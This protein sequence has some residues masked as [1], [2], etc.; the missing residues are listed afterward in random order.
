MVKGGDQTGRAA[1]Y[2]FHKALNIM[3]QVRAVYREHSGDL[4]PNDVARSIGYIEG[5]LFISLRQRNVL[6][7]AA[8]SFEQVMAPMSLVSALCQP[9][10]RLTWVADEGMERTGPLQSQLRWLV[11]MLKTGTDIVNAQAKLGKTNEL[12]ALIRGMREWTARLQEAAEAYDR[13]P[14]LPSNIQSDAHRA[15]DQA[16]ETHM[17]DIHASYKEWIENDIA[18]TTLRHIEP[19]LFHYPTTKSIGFSEESRITVEDHAKEIFGSLDL[20]LGSMQD[21]E[22][23]VKGIPTSTDDASWM[24]KEEQ[25]VGAALSA[26]HAPQ[27]SNALQTLLDK[28]QY[29]FENAKLQAIAA[30][31]AS[32]K[33]IL[34]Q[35]VASHKYLLDRFD[36]LHASTA[37]LLHRLSKSFIQIGTQGFCQPPEKSSDQ[38]QGKD[39]KL[40]SGTGLGEGEGAEDISKD[41]E[42]DEDLE[43]LAQEQKGER[44]G[45]I[46]E[47]E[48]AVDMG[49]QEMQGESE[50]VGEKEDKGDE[51][52]DEGDDDVQSEV[53][54]VDDL[55]PSAVDEKMWDDGGKEDD[56]KDKEGKE[57]VGTENQE[58]QVAS[59]QKEK[60]KKEDG[61]DGEEEEKEEKKEGQE[62][63]EMEMEGEDQEEN[64]GVGET[65]KMDPH[66]KEEETLDL[67]EDLNMDGQDDEGKEDDDLG[68]MD[69]G[70][71]LPED[72]MDPDVDP[73][74]PD[75][76]DE[77]IG[78]EKEGEEEK[79][80]TGHVEDEEQPPEDQEEEGD[81][82]M[83]DDAIPLPDEN[84]PEDEP[85][86]TKD[87]D[88]ADPNADAGAGN[89]ANEE[90][91]KNK[92]EEA[93]AS[94]ANQDEGQ[95]GDSS[96]QKQE[97]TAEDGQ[98]GQTAAPDAGG[99]GE[100]PEESKETQSFKKLGDVL[101]KWYN[102]QKQISEAREKEET[103]VQ[104]ID[105]EVDMADADFEHLGDE[106]QQADTQ[107][108]GTATE[109]Q[110]KTLDHDMAMPM[111]EEEEKMPVRPEDNEEE[112]TGADKDVEMEDAE[113][114][115]EQDPEAQQ[116][117]SN[118]AEGQ[119]QAFVG[120]QKPFPDQ[121][122]QNMEDAVPLDDDT[123]SVSSADNI[124]AQLSLT[125]LDPTTMDPTSARALWLA[126][127]AATHSLSQ[128]L[129]EH[130]RL[131]LAPTL[132]TKLRGDFRTGK[133]LNLKRIIP[134][135]ASG[136]KRDKI[137]LRRSMP[138]K[139]SYQVLIALDDSESMAKSGAA[140]LALKTL[141][142]VTRS[143]AMLEVG[144]VSVVGFGDG[145]NVAH[146]FDKP[147]T[148]EAGVRVFEQFGFDAGK[149]N[150]R[151]LVDRS[152]E[153][154]K[155]ARQRGASSAG[156]DLWQL[157]LIVSDG[158]C[159]G[160][161]E[162]QR[163]V[164]KAQEERV[165][166]V[167][168]IIDSSASENT[169][170][171]PTP[172]SSA[173]PVAQPP[174]KPE[175]PKTSIL[176][177]QSAFF[178][179]EGK[180]VRSKYMDSFPFRYYL[181]VRDVRE[182]P[183]VLA[184]ALRQW[185]GEVAG[186]V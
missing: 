80:T 156:E 95:E 43:E 151:G 139:R 87:T 40:E 74:E 91:H 85:R 23:A 109:D 111:N 166:I 143:M 92:K 21:V 167:F 152:L 141:T 101:E 63:E 1:E 51:S 177:L 30:V 16:V 158:I 183:G 172:K 67:P 125:H 15:L 161:D 149:T 106:E 58:E 117:Q 70:D 110:A 103:Q 55:G 100:Q 81:E 90:A 5:L 124:E 61:E 37:S 46:E 104:Q 9:D 112:T 171:D 27:I 12:D 165:M 173:N 14:K 140:S 42:D 160:H 78:P 184:G 38:Q 134:Y 131:I 130:L 157:M 29:L 19:F 148:S 176:D 64:V 28:V 10:E 57:D 99:H 127:E 56:A 115:Q 13:L 76:I 26:L 31:F 33:P 68:D 36:A 39:E 71:D 53:G 32:I 138:S 132:A 175:Q 182:L 97:T 153:L 145:V 133:R 60:E 114:Q 89:E 146:D 108:L 59:E 62:D 4:T 22:A 54:S 65:E 144:E 164:R 169:V 136:Y 185:F 96:E 45:S 25:A 73:G 121:E 41:I 83:D 3:P 48:D 178:T 107:A 2:H 75:T 129:T 116:Q 162:I 7:K 52:G 159:D 69:M 128:Q 137:W 20:I 98:L 113:E 118:S 102:Q 126:H 24:V 179:N 150:V 119:P 35:Y 6:S 82:P 174:A 17:T 11:A 84:V 18:K 154:F 86:D 34:D 94:A 123:S 50:E 135:I 120:E 122:D 181:V 88:Q 47:Q 44:E 79:D 105:K 66:A 93:S 163:L 170:S 8:Q 49:D 180:L 186:S 155:D 142:L 72:E 168:V 147:F 77:E